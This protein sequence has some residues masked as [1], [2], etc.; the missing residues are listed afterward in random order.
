MLRLASDIDYI[1]EDKTNQLINNSTE[2]SKSISGLI[3]TL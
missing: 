1:S 3:K 2:I